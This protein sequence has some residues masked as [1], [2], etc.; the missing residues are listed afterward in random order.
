MAANAVAHG[1]SCLSI[2]IRD[3]IV[4]YDQN[5][6]YLFLVL[7]SFLQKNDLGMGNK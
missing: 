2:I 3:V 6:G 4:F 1:L 5:N 7:S